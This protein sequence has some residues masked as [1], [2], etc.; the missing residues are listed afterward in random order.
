M[1]IISIASVAGFLLFVIKAT[2][3][4]GSSIGNG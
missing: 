2:I 4:G 1:D 3:G